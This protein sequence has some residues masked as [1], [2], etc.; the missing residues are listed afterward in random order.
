[1]TIVVKTCQYRVHSFTVGINITKLIKK[2]LKSAS[3]KRMK[4]GIV[5]DLMRDLFEWLKKSDEHVLI[6]LCI[7]L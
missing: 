5:P 7:S 4:F 6:I 1:M 3:R 2:R